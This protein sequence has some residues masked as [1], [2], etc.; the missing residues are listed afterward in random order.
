M[1]SDDT[2][3]EGLQAPGMSLTK[4]E[5]LEVAGLLSESG[6]KTAL[7]SYPSA[8]SSEIEVTREI[9]SRGFFRETFG[10][11]RTLEK[12][13]DV[14]D[15]TGADIALHLPFKFDGTSEIVKA[16]GYASS[17]GR[18]LEVA[19][20]DVIKYREDMLVKLCGD[21]VNAGTDILQLPDTTGM[22]NPAKFEQIISNIRKKFRDVEIEV[23]CHNDYGLSTTNAI[24]GIRAG[25]DRVDTAVYGL[26]ERNGITDQMVFATYLENSGIKTGIDMGKLTKVYD[27]VLELIMK[28]MGP[29]FFS[30]NY[31]IAGSNVSVHTA[32]THAAFSDVF[33]A[34]EFSVNVY[35]G[36][37][38]VRK[39]LEN[40]GIKTTDDQLA[41]IVNRI[42][43][44]AVETGM[45][46]K[47]N[48][49]RKIAGEIIG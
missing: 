22:A 11:G 48:D 45:A 36:K 6:L 31:P 28:K 21:L 18:T 25:A 43:D 23:H 10:L 41:A 39:I 37:S 20:V 17:K 14:I 44:E 24:A 26:G 1:I 34:K 8:H 3:R 15:S 46:L 4:D 33:H 30:K 47:T 27:R 13:I 49:I 32:G 38:M 19:V 7:V 16:V 12:D 5:K 40:S 2:L 29:E 35:T 9:V 42:K